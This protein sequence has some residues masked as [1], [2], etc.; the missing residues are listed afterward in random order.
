MAMDES[1]ETSHPTISD[2]QG[3]GIAKRVRGSGRHGLQERESGDR[4]KLGVK[5]LPD[6]AP[7]F[8]SLAGL[9][10]K[11]E[12]ADDMSAGVAGLGPQTLLGNGE[13][14]CY[15]ADLENMVKL[16]RRV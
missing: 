7:F 2:V 6:L 4:Q 8:V 16:M 14:E 11:S 13:S 12:Q 15:P 5:Q 10:E 9:T 3:S 1:D